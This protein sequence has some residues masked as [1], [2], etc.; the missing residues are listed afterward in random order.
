MSSPGNIRSG[1]MCT[2]FTMIAGIVAILGAAL[3]V[4][5]Q[6]TAAISGRVV[7]ASGAGVGGASITAKSGETGATR[8]ATT[9]NEG[10]YRVDSLPLGAMEVHAIKA[11]F[12]EAVRKGIDLVL[13]QDASVNIRLEVG[14]KI[15]QIDIV[16]GVPT[17]NIT[18]A[19]IS[20][21]VTEQQVK[22]LPLNGRSLDVLITTNP[23]T[24]NY[25]ALKSSGTTTSDGNTF[26]VAGRRPGDN[27]FLLNGVE[28]SGSS[29]LAVTPGGVSGE[30]L[31]IDGIRE[32][33][34]LT[35]TYGAQYGK[36]AGAQ[37]AIVTQS[38]TNVLHG[39]VFE[40]L[41]NSALDARN[42]FD[43]ASVPPFRRNQFGGALGGPI[44]KNKLFVFGNY[45]GFRQSLAL[46]SVSVVPDNQARQ[47]LL[48]NATT[49][50]YAKVANL[51]TGML[52]Y[53]VFWPAVNGPELTQTTSAGLV[54]P[55]GTAYSYNNPKQ[56]IHEDF[57]TTR[58]DYTLSDRG[59]RFALLHDRHRQQRAAPDGSVVHR[60]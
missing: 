34:V 27:Q 25:S 26:S 1:Q 59:F 7:D 54:V 2:R 40:Y 8:S 22:D 38:G 50:I 23:G 57:G 47:G 4:Q 49:G 39:S 6:V 37:V 36:R 42:F 31:G 46:T 14:D 15:T 16:E 44:R 56:L 58:A 18:T 60:S 10:N 9:D 45:E 20:G 30:L 13:G 32:V 12:K 41:R 55:T 35:D 53:M 28:Y 19:P 52:P 3:P 29:Q 43:Q 17:V 21:L 48:P 5:A 33:N 51:N 11:G 24:I